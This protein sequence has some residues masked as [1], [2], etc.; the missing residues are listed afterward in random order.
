L[1]VNQGKF[2]RHNEQPEYDL[3]RDRREPGDRDTLNADRYLF[4]ELLRSAR[5]RL[6]LTA[7]GLTDGGEAAPL[8][9]VAQT[10]VDWL[11]REYTLG[12]APAGQAVTVTYPLSPASPRYR[13]G[14]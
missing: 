1:G 13:S 6:I 9:S 7:G 5:D 8:S 4:L 3:M 11:D 12:A 2:P 10:L 14:K